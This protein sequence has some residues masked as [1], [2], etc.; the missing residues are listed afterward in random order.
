MSL[1][2]FWA[3]SAVGSFAVESRWGHFEALA[4]WQ[5]PLAVLTWIGAVTALRRD[6]VVFTIWSLLALG[7]TLA[8]IG[9]F[10][11]AK[12]LIYITAYLWM[13]SSALSLYRV[14]AYFLADTT[15]HDVQLPTAKRRKRQAGTVE[16]EYGHAVREPGV[17]RSEY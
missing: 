11:P 12:G 5:A 13:A 14:F 9:W 17:S 15:E 10:A 6:G 7:S 3:A 16:W 4:I 8:L 1:A 2:L